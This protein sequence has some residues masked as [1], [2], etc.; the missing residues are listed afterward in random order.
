MPARN[1][2]KKFA[3]HQMWHV[4]NRGTFGRNIFADDLDYKVLLSYF[5]I[6]LTEEKPG[7]EE[8]K[9]MPLLENIINLR[10]MQLYKSVELVSY[11]L[12]PNHY[13]LLLYQ[14]DEDGITRLMRSI[15]TGYAMYYNRRHESYGHLF[16]GPYKGV[17]VDEDE[18][19][20]HISRY[21]HLNP[22]DIS[23]DYKSYE[24]SSY[25]YTAGA[26]VPT[27]LHPEHILKAFKPGEYKQF[28][29]DYESHKKSVKD[30]K[31]LLAG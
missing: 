7:K 14:Y 6:C 25:K 11:C 3:P 20:Q 12:M 9:N 18:Y 30:M 21:I 23:R 10:R 13:H 4:Y 1:S 28:V 2:I 27:W 17:H 22:T 29:A 24:Y 5:K 16:Q 8:L 19:W 15:M 31:H 26:T